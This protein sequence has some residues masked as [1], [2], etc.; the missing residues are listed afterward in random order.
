VR[1]DRRLLAVT[2]GRRT[3]WVK[4]QRLFNI[5]AGTYIDV[6]GVECSGMGNLAAGSI[7]D[8]VIGIFIALILEAALWPVVD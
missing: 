3:V 8:G 7:P 1:T 2:V 4:W 5:S 6:G